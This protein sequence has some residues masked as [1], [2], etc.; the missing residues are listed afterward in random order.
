MNPQPTTVLCLASYEKGEDL[1]R[2]LKNQ[3]CH[4]ILVTVEKL[5]DSALWPRAAIDELLFVAEM[6]KQPDITYAISYI[7]RSRK[8]DCIIALDEFD[9]EIAA[10][11][12]EHLRIPGMGDTTARYFRD[13]LAMRVQAKDSGIRVP[14]F[15]PVINYDDL[16]EFMACVPPP[17]VLKPRTSAS[18]IG[19]KKIQEAEELWRTLDELGDQQSFQVLEKYIPGE[20]FHVDSVVSENE[21]VFAA[22]HKYGAPPLNVMHDGGIFTTG[23]IPRASTD[24]LALQTLNAEI[25]KAFKL[26]RGVT[27]TEFI[28][29]SADGQFYFLETASR[30]GGAYIAEVVKAAT[31]INLWTEWARVEIAQCQNSG[32]SLP[33][34]KQN[35]AGIILSL[36]RQECPDT[37][38][39]DAPEIIYRVNKKNH[40]GLIVASPDQQRVQSLIENYTARFYQDFYASAPAPDKPTT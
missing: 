32:Y 16:R 9:I 4:V 38:A 24:D 26:V 30:V 11:L 31:G 17:W 2:E 29:S 23:G 12:R 3:G 15:S 5:K 8:I 20:I 39:Y 6:T 7:A 35:Y 40:A 34:V 37:S 21:V 33:E 13:K 25:I 28:K 36:A 18:A 10:A 1:L 19:I 27:H 22:V 14:E